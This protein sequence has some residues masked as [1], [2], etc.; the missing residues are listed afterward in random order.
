MRSVRCLNRSTLDLLYKL[1]V[2]SVIDY[3]LTIYFHTLKQTEISRLNQ[4]QYRAAKLCTGALHLTS[5]QKLEADLGWESLSTR[6][7]FLGLCQFQKFHLHESRPLVLRCMPEINIARTTRNKD[8]YR[9]FKKL[10]DKFSNSFFP[11]FTKQFNNL[12]VNLQ[13]EHDLPTFKENLKRKLKPKKYKHFNWGSKRGNALLT[14]LRVG[15]SFLNSHSFAINLADSDLCLCSRPESTRHYFN[16]CFLYTEERRVLY[17]SMEQLIPKF[18]TFSEKMKT[19][20]LLNGINIDSEEFDSRNSKIIYLVQDF[21]FKTK[22][23]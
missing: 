14:Q 11:Y 8:F 22:R 18:K 6:A 9:P 20:V 5:Q 3:G 12:D 7:N 15:R 19:D 17:N 2:R 10:G 13:I 1:T 4:L 16:Q 21:I 23:F